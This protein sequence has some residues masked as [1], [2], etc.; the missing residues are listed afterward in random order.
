MTRRFAMGFTSEGECA[1]D[2]RA[3]G[4]GDSLKRMRELRELSKEEVA[5][6]LRLRLGIIDLLE[7]KSF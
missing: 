2:V 5:H 3:E 6:R 7:S 4:I 1:I